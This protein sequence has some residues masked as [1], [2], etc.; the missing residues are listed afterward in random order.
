MTST[1]ETFVL[2]VGGG[3]VGL[4]AALD[5]AQRN[6]PG[7]LITENVVTAQHPRCNFVNGR[8]MEH[9]RRLGLADAIRAIAPLAKTRPRVAFATRFCGYEFGSIDLL[10]SRFETPGPEPGVNISQLF[11]EPLLRDCA[12]RASSVDVRFGWRLTAFAVEQNGAIASVEDVRSGERKCIRARY[13]IGADGA[14]SPIRRHFG[15]AMAGDE[16]RIADAFVSG[17]MITYFVRAPTLM[18]ESRRQPAVLTW[19]VNHDLRA[20]V[21]SQD[22]GE[23]WIIHYQVPDGVRWQEVQS[24]VVLRGVFGKDVPYEIITLGPWA[25]GLS[26]VADTYR[27]GP[28]FLAGDAAHLY[29]PLGAFGMNTGIGDAMN[30]TWKI[31]AIH[32]GWGGERLLDSYEAER[33]PI[34]FRN[35]KIGIH[36][37]KRKGKWDIPKEIEF[38]DQAGEFAR[39]RFGDFVVVDD[40]DEYDT[41]GLQFG[42]CY[43][44]SPIVHQ[45][46]RHPPP[47]TWAIYTPTDFP[48]ARSPH[49]WFGPGRS[50]Y[51]LIGKDYTLL[52]FDSG[53]PLDALREAARCRNMPLTVLNCGSIE[54]GHGSRLVL[55]RPDQHI[56]WH[57]DTLPSDSLTLVDR[58]RGA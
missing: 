49:F 37:S 27:M 1:E 28:V 24:E 12:E 58:V 45:N 32:A 48:G 33:R 46:D 30:L 53:I 26:L 15:I 44:G 25:G 17:T 7:I 19:I 54:R 29:T 47:D 14:R 21:F 8:T 55:T 22:G 31:G 50:V 57:G 9:F 40:L 38:D 41:F 51:D 13:V 56:A 18:A 43:Q 11:L 42:E 39:A 3:P 36:C 10:Q 34:G 4:T 16:G 6:V 2:I 20:F 23:R 35:S 52:D 5:L